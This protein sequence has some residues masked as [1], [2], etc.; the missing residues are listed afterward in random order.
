MDQIREV[1]KSEPIAS[2][3]NFEI[4][5]LH[6]QLVRLEK[7][8]LESAF[9]LSW[10]K[11]QCD[12]ADVGYLHPIHVAIWLHDRS[13]FVGVDV[14][15]SE[16]EA[17]VRKADGVC[18][19][20][21]MLF[22]S[23]GFASSNEVVSFDFVN[24]ISL[25]AL[26]LHEDNLVFPAIDEFPLT[27]VLT[28]GHESSGNF[29]ERCLDVCRFLSLARPPCEAVQPKLFTKGW[30]KDAPFPQGRDIGLVARPRAKLQAPVIQLEL[31][32]ANEYL[33]NFEALESKVQDRVRTVLDHYSYCLSNL[34]LVESAIHMRICLEA[35]LMQSD[36]G[37][38]TF[39]VSRRGALMLGGELSER[40][41]HCNLIISAYKA[42]SSA[43]HSASV[44]ASESTQWSE[45]LKVLQ[46]LTRSWFIAGAPSLSSH[47]WKLVEL[48]G[49][50]PPAV[51]ECDDR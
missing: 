14:A 4:T 24:G 34:T 18:P 37:D 30:R 25:T 41:R 39:K 8:L 6:P 13:Q 10:L 36:S 46:K 49:G 2:T 7:A 32:V 26:E 45:L 35:L 3:R 20:D 38:N 11:D 1:L 48:G 9:V 44:K 23:L 22:D 47:E 27:C 21:V 50:F 19:V 29:T 5:Y 42:G 43:V 16:L 33:R 51:R 31:Q 28:D 15:L 12:V 40:E 17:V